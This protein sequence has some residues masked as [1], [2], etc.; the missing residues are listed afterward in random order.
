MTAYTLTI[1]GLGPHKST[2][3]AIPE[4]A[5]LRGPSTVG[6]STTAHA[7]ALLLQGALP[8][9]AADLAALT[10]SDRGG[11]IEIELQR[12]GQP[13]LS[14]RRTAA[15]RVTWAAGLSQ[16]SN[17]AGR[18]RLLGPVGET[19]LADLTLAILSPNALL[20][21]I[22][23]PGDRGRP[24]RLALDLALPAQDLG[25]VVDEVL[26]AAG[27][28]ARTPSEPAGW[29][30]AD[31]ARKLA[32]SDAD[33]AAGALSQAGLPLPAIAPSSAPTP[34]ALAAARATVEAAELWATYRRTAGASERRAQ[35]LAQAADWDRRL[36][37][38]GPQPS[39]D[40]A[41]CPPAL[42]AQAEHAAV[43]V[44]DKAL[45]LARIAKIDDH[46]ACADSLRELAKAR[47][48]GTTCG[49]CGG[50]LSPEGKGRAIKAAEVRLGEDRKAAKAELAARVVKAEAAL[51]EARRSL[52]AAE[53]RVAQREQERMGHTEAA[54]ERSTWQAGRKA[55]GDRPTVPAPAEGAPEPPTCDEPTPSATMGARS[56]IAAH[57]AAV[58]QA[59][60]RATQERQHAAALAQAEQ[61]ADAASAALTRS[62]AIADAW[63]DA[64]GIV[65]RAGMAAW[66]AALDTADPQHRLRLELPEPTAPAAEQ[67]TCK[68]YVTGGQ[69]LSLPLAAASTGRRV[70]AALSLALA[71]RH[72][73]AARYPGGVLPFAEL[74]VV[75]DD[76]QAWSEVMPAAVGP[77]WLL[78]TVAS[79]PGG[80]RQITVRAL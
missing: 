59:E 39:Y 63:R 36:A 77:L 55:L 1:A 23:S 64:P 42:S 71:L 17:A 22:L 10:R 65:A 67:D 51:E 47:A 43:D 21:S 5:E 50:A 75:L 58:A 76:V 54:L 62:Q 57:E 56:V 38:L 66:Q 80:A 46:P 6:K 68:L 30:A 9:G 14:Y 24:L 26:E 29:K 4:A 34:E 31:A 27:H 40:G 70:R 16:E 35:L 69:G 60:A 79:T 61:R 7:L 15:G 72:L 44:A 25:R 74:P 49:A 11:V 41:P 37:A 12:P 18:A 2:T 33:R 73:A 3:L 20:A 52:R 48:I 13:G 53:A 28:T 45:G 8:A 78:R 19:A 32:K